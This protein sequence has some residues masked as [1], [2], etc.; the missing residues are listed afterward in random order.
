MGGAGMAGDVPDEVVDSVPDTVVNGVPD[1]GLDGAPP[2]AIDVV[3]DG[4]IS[5][6]A[7]VAEEPAAFTKAA[8]CAL[9]GTDGARAGSRAAVP[10][11]AGV[12]AGIATISRE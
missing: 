8:T 9:P 3:P 4:A 2:D 11:V 1:T 7:A 12:A 10:T 5:I 6:G